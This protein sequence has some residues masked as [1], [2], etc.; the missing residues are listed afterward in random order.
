MNKYQQLMRKF[1]GFAF[2]VGP[3]LYFVGTLF[4]P[5]GNLGIGGMIAP[6]GVALLIPVFMEMGRWIGQVQP[7]YGFVCTVLALLTTAG[8]TASMFAWATGEA[9]TNDLA[10]TSEETWLY[11][12]NDPYIF[13]F[14]MMAVLFPIMS[15]LIAIGLWRNRIVSRWIPALFL[16][17]SISFLIFVVGAYLEEIMF[18]VPV[19]I[20]LLALAPMGWRILTGDLDEVVGATAVA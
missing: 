4:M 10:L 3:L 19:F 9:L 18:P 20:W 6:F 7:R 13:P 5:L 14:F 2:I 16:V 15:I 17:A 11:S 8:N 12:S 1:L